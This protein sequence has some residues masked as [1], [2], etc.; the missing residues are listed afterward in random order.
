MR[1]SRRS[2]LRHL[3]PYASA[4][5]LLATVLTVDAQVDCIGTVHLR[6]T[7]AACR[8]IVFLLTPPRSGFN[9]DPFF[10]AFQVNAGGP[11]PFGL[12]Y[13]GWT[14]PLARRHD[15]A[16]AAFMHCSSRLNNHECVRPA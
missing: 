2:A 4:V 6:G 1:V 14:H 10:S 9:F 8:R 7:R 15:S 12:N 11:N 5:V 13:D 3:R 16:A